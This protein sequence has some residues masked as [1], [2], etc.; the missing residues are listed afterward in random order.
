[1]KLRNNNIRMMWVIR[2]CIIIYAMGLWLNNGMVIRAMETEVE[3]KS[4]GESETEELSYQGK[5]ILVLGDSISAY[6]RWT[7]RFEEIVQPDVFI[8]VAVAGA[9]LSDNVGTRYNGSPSKGNKKN[10]TLGNQVEKVKIKKRLELKRYQDFQSIIIFAGTNDSISKFRNVDIEKQFTT[11]KSTYR[12]LKKIDKTTIAGSMRYSVETLQSLYP[13]AQIFICTTIQSA[14]D[15]KGYNSNYIIKNNVIKDVAYRLSVPVIDVGECGIYGRY[16]TKGSEG[17]Y[18]YDGL[19]P[20]EK[21]GKL[22][23]EYI[24]REYIGWYIF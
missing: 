24:S 19:H 20:N 1:M 21:G 16:E 8:N 9:T 10:N 4:V 23:G 13:D 18:L 22:L 11:T 6:G 17:K 2:S 15:I 3:V 12:S 5:K 14:E 7:N